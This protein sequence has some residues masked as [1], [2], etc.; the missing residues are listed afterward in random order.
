MSYI[1]HP[2][3]DQ[4]GRAVVDAHGSGALSVSVGYVALCDLSADEAESH[5]ALLR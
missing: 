3:A 5:S 4:G 1:Q 2:H